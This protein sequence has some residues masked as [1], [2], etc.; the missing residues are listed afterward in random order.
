MR[1]IAA[2]VE[3][4]DRIADLVLG[5]TGIRATDASSEETFWAVRR[6]LE[7]LARD[8]P[9]LVL[10]EDVH[11]AEPTFLDLVEYLI[12]WTRDAP[13]GVLAVCAYGVPADKASPFDPTYRSTEYRTTV[14]IAFGVER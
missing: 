1:A 13:E 7:T 8:R 11:W 4:A 14:D 3:E 6:L 2:D 10:F 9:L 12:G 5:A